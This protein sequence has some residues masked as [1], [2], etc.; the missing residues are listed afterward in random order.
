MTCSTCALRLDTRVGGFVTLLSGEC[1]CL[2]CYYRRF[3]K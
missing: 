1:L 2:A 3:G